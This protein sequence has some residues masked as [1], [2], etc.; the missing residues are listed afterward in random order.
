MNGARVSAAVCDLD[1]NNSGRSEEYAV[2]A[3]SDSL[4][5]ERFRD[6]GDEAS[7]E[8][9]FLRHYPMVYG[10][11]Y[12]LTGS[13]HEAEDLA[14]EVFVK[15]YRRPIQRSENIAGWLYRVAINTGYNALRA[16][17]R[18][19]RRE[20]AA[21]REAPSVPQTE[22]LVT[23]RE[24]QRRVRMALA[25]ISPRA[26]KLLILREMGMG[27]AEIAGVIGVSPGSV[28]TLLIRAQ[29]ELQR[30]FKAVAGPGDV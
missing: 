18:R 6:L 3:T 25:K 8:A 21:A 30:A 20:Q 4:L 5:I 17:I 13:H 28:G 12:R 7:F 2:T 1:G 22:D 24:T 11:L 29:K 19:Y 15:L 9:L 10:V 23:Q 14:Q 16:D 26:A 27:Y